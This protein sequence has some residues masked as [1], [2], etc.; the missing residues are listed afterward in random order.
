MKDFI[1]F[2]QNG[3]HIILYGG[4]GGVGKTSIAAATSILCSNLGLKTLITSSDPAH[5][6]SDVFEQESLMGGEITPVETCENLFALET[7]PKKVLDEYSHY[8]EEY[9]ELK[10]LLGEDFEEFPGAN[11]GFGLLNI[12]RRFNN[13]DWD[14]IIVDTA[15]TGHTLKLLSFPDFLSKTTIKLIRIRNALGSFV[16]KITNFFRRRNAEPKDI[17]E[18]LDIAKDWSE[19]TQKVLSNKE[20]SRFMVVMIPELLSINETD[21]L[22]SNLSKFNIPVGKIFVNKFF[23]KDT[24]CS[25]C[26][27][28]RAKQDENLKI[29]NEKFND[30]EIITIP[31]FEDEIHGVKMLEKLKLILY[32][33]NF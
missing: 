21:R 22:I 17:S 27:K 20:L 10:I 23:P 7:D 30:Y 29:I 16:N 14:I 26:S 5:S 11:E 32:S 13:E 8:L 15:P 4:K 2:L 6:L 3:K 28:K 9:P 19:E 24:D 18:F 25:F 33:E 1:E 12:I 31:Y